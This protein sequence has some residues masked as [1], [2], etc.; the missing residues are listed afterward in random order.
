MDDPSGEAESVAKETVKPLSETHTDDEASSSKENAEILALAQERQL[1]KDGQETNDDSQVETFKL[2]EFG[3]DPGLPEAPE[4]N[5]SAEKTQKCKNEENEETS[6]EM[7]LEES[8]DNSEIE[9]EASAEPVV[10]TGTQ[11]GES[12]STGPDDTDDQ[13]TEFSGDSSLYGI[14]GST[15]MAKN[16]GKCG[17]KKEP[18]SE[19]SFEESED[20]FSLNTG[21]ADDSSVPFLYG[22]SRRRNP[23]V[24]QSWG[25]RA[26]P[27]LHETPRTP[28]VD[29]FS[30]KRAEQ[31]V[32]AQR[33]AEKAQEKGQYEEA[34]SLCETA[35]QT[36]CLHEDIN[37]HVM[38]CGN[39]MQLHYVMGNTDEA[40]NTYFDRC[41][42]ILQNSI[43]RVD[44]KVIQTIMDLYSL[45]FK[46]A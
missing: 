26:G 12:Q 34:L 30:R 11:E 16:G 8:E 2:T 23:F 40:L 24:D 44:S 21:L 43:D 18:H 4:S 42:A 7:S 41:Q 28:F 29:E 3:C 6:S 17:N 14:S 22:R 20:Y 5:A 39:I 1:Q 46:N 9:G 15:A 31:A 38:I 32:E 19:M 25:R 37:L 35:L 33:L 27:F 10:L 45:C 13:L 36:L